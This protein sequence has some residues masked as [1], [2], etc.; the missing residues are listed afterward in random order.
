M[1]TEYTIRLEQKKDYRA[2]EELT[3]EAF[4]NVYRP[5]CLEHYVL[6]R[7]RGGKDFIPSLDFVMEKDG[8]IIGHI[9]Y[10]KSSITADD[11]REIPVVTFG[12]VSILPSYQNKGYGTA[13]IEFSMQRAK[14][15]G[16][17]AIAIAG[18]IGFYKRFGFTVAKTAGIR[19]FDDPDAEYFLIVE[20]EKG[21]LN[22]IS[23]SY[24]DPEEYFVDETEAEEFDKTFPEKERR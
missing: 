6:H 22:G 14:E 18:D 21:F 4:Y 16:A 5:G 17:K 11:G 3:R 1:K 8:K 7:F 23:G 20:L 15:Y 24:K 19:Y 13:L 10:A 12:P 2:A 9:M